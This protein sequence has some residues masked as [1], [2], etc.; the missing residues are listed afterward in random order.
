MKGKK[1]MKF[2]VKKNEIIAAMSNIQG[3]TGRKSNLVITSSILLNATKDGITISATDLET[4]FEGSYQAA[5]E[6]EGAIA[7][8]ARK[9][10]EIIK[11]FPS[12]EILVNEVAN[13]WIQ[14][15]NENIEYHISGMHPD[16]FPTLPEFEDVDFFEVESEP[17]KRMIEHV[18]AIGFSDD[19]R[20]HIVGAYVEKIESDGNE[21]IIR[22]VSTDGS[23]LAKSDI[24]LG[25]DI[26]INFHNG[27]IVPKKGLSDVCKFLDSKN[28]VQI[29][30]NSNYFIVKKSS[31]TIIIRL[32]EG[33]FP[34]YQDIIKKADEANVI[35]L[36]RQLF[37]MMLKRM[38]I[39]TSDSY[40]GVIFNFSDDK[41]LIS[42]TNP[43]IGES[44]E[45]MII[46]FSGDPIEV[47]FNSRYFM[48]SLN[49][50]DD[51]KVYLNIVDA[52]RPCLIEGET[53]KNYLSVIMPMRI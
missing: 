10:Y 12:D 38:S 8:N 42:S 19:K 52:E 46:G 25:K 7:I 34:K 3:L 4:G 29:G 20:A 21:L 35:I 37:L 40:R 39:L 17:F 16:D 9:F 15:G 2:T 1:S 14:I 5:V 18:T 32:L 47:A 27:I 45:E 22:M 41:L 36:N 23:R 48:E 50:M 51:D 53:D 28:P 6:S 43:D 24:N 44:R 26:T 33:E 11:E 31:E 13:Q 49:V 30:C